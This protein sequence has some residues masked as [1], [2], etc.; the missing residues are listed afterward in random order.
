ML[1]ASFSLLLA[2]CSPHH[3][4][5]HGDITPS[6]H[7]TKTQDEADSPPH[8]SDAVDNNAAEDD[9]YGN[10][11]DDNADNGTDVNADNDAVMQTTD[12]N[13]DDDGACR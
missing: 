7:P 6:S 8:P 11:A 2:V 10:T 4:P 3:L 5:C 9:A 13:T 12:D 1:F